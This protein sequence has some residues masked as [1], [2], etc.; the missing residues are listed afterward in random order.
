MSEND[1]TPDFYAFAVNKDGKKPHYT[2]IGAAWSNAK[3]GYGLRLNALPVNNEILL[4]PPRED[5]DEPVP[6]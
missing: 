2:R 1:N 6:S 5:G 3:G 4:F